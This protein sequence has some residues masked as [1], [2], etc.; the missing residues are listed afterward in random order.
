MI[1][2]RRGITGKLLTGMVFL[3]LLILLIIWIFQIVFLKGFY[4]N[5][6]K[7]TLLGEGKKIANL[8]SGN[9]VLNTTPEIRDELI[10]YA[11]SLP[12]SIA[13][14]DSNNNLREYVFFSDAQIRP[15]ERIEDLARRKMIDWL[16]KDP[17]I[18]EKIAGQQ[19]F[20]ITNTKFRRPFTLVGIPITSNNQWLGT[21]ILETPL[22][23]IEESTSILKKQL[24]IITFISLVIGIIFALLISRHLTKP[25]LQISQ[26]AENIAKGDF[27]TSIKIKSNDEIGS[28]GQIINNLPIELQKLENFR[29]DFI[30]NTTHELKTPISLIQ[31][32]AELI[33]DL[34]GEKK[35]VRDRNLQVIIDEADRLNK[36]VEDILYLSQ[37]QPEDI[38]LN[39]KDFLVVNT[40]K[41]VIQKLSFLAKKKNIQIDFN[42]EDESIKVHG[43]EERLYQVFFN[44][45]NNAIIYSRENTKVV[46]NLT[47]DKCIEII[48]N[49]VGIPEKDLPYIWDRFYKVDKSRKR[50]SNSTGLGLAI[51]KNILDAHLFPYGVE[52]RINEGSVFWIQM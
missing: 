14:L 43:D 10:S 16:Q 19:S 20:S 38:K 35:D 11:A 8:Y 39:S 44:I 15:F 29:K 5:E 36:I 23:P 26:A 9:E 51:V 27:N 25:I 6:R 22:A 12:G 18:M 47:T 42:F 21:L 17:Q 2:L 28:L 24:S 7:N 40:V 13:I 41:N 48:D 3:V 37:I 45:L 50:N 31:A 34:E 4:I 52:S 46:I 33:R 30:T 32:Y 49:G 1:S